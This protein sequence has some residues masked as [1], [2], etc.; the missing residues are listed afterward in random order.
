MAHFSNAELAQKLS[1][2]V[3]YW[4]SFNEEYANWL[5]GTVTGGPGSDGKYTVTDYQDNE[6][7]IE[8]PAKLADN[9]SGY[10]GDASG[11]ADA[12][13]ASA[14]AAATSESNAST[15][16]TTATAQAA[17]ADADRISAETA[18]SGAVDAKN[19]SVTQANLATAR[20]GYAEEWANKAFESLVSA[21]AGGDEVDDYSALHWATVAE[22]FAGSVDSGLYGQLAQD[23]IVTG[24]WGFSGRIHV[25]G[26]GYELDPTGM[27]LGL[28]NATEAYLQIPGTTGSISIWNG[29]SGRI[30]NF[31]DNGITTLYGTLSGV[32]G[33]FSGNVTGANLNVSNW[34]TAYGWGDWSAHVHEGTA[35]DATAVTDGYVLTADGAGNAVWEA[36]GAGSEVNDL[37]AAVTWTNIPIA[38]VPTGTSGVTVAL[39]NHLHTGVYEPVDA[40][41]VRDDDA[42]YNNTNW[43][44]AYGW[45]NHAS[46]YLLL[47]GGSLSS[48]LDFGSN[49]GATAI[50]LSKHIALWGTTYGFNV[51]AN[52]LNFTAAG[53]NSMSLLATQVDLKKNTEVTGT[54]N[55]SGAIT[56]S[57]LA[58][59]NW[60]TAYGWGDHSGLYEAADAD[61]VKADVVETIAAIWTHTAALKISDGTDLLSISA[62]SGVTTFQPTGGMSSVD[63]NL[64]VT[65][66][67]FGG[68][69]SANL[70]D[71]SAVETIAGAWNFTGVPTKSALGIPYHV[72]T[73]Y[74]GGK[75][76]VASSAPGSPTKGDIWF[77]T[78]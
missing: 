48:G 10:V 75:I 43:D 68:I 52:T 8:C 74:V 23:E 70:V 18:E 4:S 65:A 61:I 69:T 64:A 11:Y 3:A 46:T 34:D 35:I 71:K 33:T 76:T 66:N 77:D 51:T 67:S 28:Y 54:L 6:S 47:T 56:G 73:G 40:T 16:A 36:V 49:V 22:G 57:N 9:V 37:S 13:A 30:A 1:D 14:A 78:S 38:N 29:G 17:L 45:G 21:A 25:T 50:D 42:G 59:A 60:N 58:V 53:V 39:G 63:F 2:L 5:G 19:T 27:L 15:S 24:A 41:L 31:N 32:A 55:A 20:A 26:S 7:L 72:S 62:V 44:T 12:A